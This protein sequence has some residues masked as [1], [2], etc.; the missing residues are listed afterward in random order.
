MPA[1]RAHLSLVTD[2]RRIQ[3]SSVTVPK[4]LRP[5]GWQYL[6]GWT[7][8]GWALISIH[9]NA[10]REAVALLEQR[11]GGPMRL[12]AVVTVKE[13]DDGT[14][15]LKAVTDDVPGIPDD[16]DQGLYSW[17]KAGWDLVDIT[18]NREHGAW[19]MFTK[20]GTDDAEVAP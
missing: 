15:K 10:D 16:W 6:Q 2:D 4:D 12:V 1:L 5:N 18:G 8:D 9:G 14:V 11:W 19:W 20:S 7:D 17:T 13:K 3:V